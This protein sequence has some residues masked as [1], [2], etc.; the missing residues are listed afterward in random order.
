[1]PLPSADELEQLQ[2]IG[3]NFSRK[4]AIDEEIL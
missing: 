2:D 4:T 3:R 1:M